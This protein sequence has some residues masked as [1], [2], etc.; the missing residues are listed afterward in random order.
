MYSSN[1]GDSAKP[2]VSAHFR[3]WTDVFE[4]LEEEAKTHKVSLNALV[5]Q[6]LSSHTRDELL[7]EEF[8]YLKMRKDVFRVILAMLPDDKMEE[9]G[10]QTVSHGSAAEMLARSGAMNLEAVLEN[11]R[12][13]S[14]FGWFSVYEKKTGGRRTI[15][16]IHDFGPKYSTSLSAA[17]TSQFAL[18]GIRPKITTTDSSVMVDY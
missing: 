4:S 12:V 3:V 1:D 16:L 9:L 13:S 18:V 2:S 14:R 7:L 10:R 17:V 11:L 8:G 15:S 6:L 5:N